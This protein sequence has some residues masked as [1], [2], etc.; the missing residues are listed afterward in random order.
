MPLLLYGKKQNGRNNGICRAKRERNGHSMTIG[1]V[2]LFTNAVLKSKHL[3]HILDARPDPAVRAAHRTALNGHGWYLEAI[4]KACSC[5][6]AQQRRNNKIAPLH[7]PIDAPLDRDFHFLRE[8]TV[9][10]QLTRGQP[11][12]LGSLFGRC[13]TTHRDD[14]DAFS[15]LLDRD[16]HHAACR[17][18]PAEV[19]AANLFITARHLSPCPLVHTFALAW[20]LGD[21]ASISMAPDSCCL[22]AAEWGSCR[23]SDKR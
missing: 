6:C 22:R 11:D 12:I 16:T 5:D 13:R 17:R 15:C 23:L 18:S 3:A 20:L 7:F 21:Q 4:V 9:G 14:V 8:A 10:C 19:V 1:G 2:F